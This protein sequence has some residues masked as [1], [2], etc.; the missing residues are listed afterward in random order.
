MDIEK[1]KRAKMKLDQETKER[2]QRL[3]DAI[4]AKREFEL[5]R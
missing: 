1:A 4:I 2:A 3:Q 5:N